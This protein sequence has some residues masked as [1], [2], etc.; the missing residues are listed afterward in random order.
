MV[1]S[2]ER[3]GNIVYLCSPLEEREWVWWAADSC[4]PHHRYSEIFTLTWRSKGQF[5]QLLR[6]ELALIIKSQRSPLRLLVACFLCTTIALTS[7]RKQGMLNP[8]LL[9]I[10]Y[11]LI[12]TTIILFCWLFFLKFLPNCFTKTNYTIYD[13]HVAGGNM[14]LYLMNE[15]WKEIYQNSK[16]G[17]SRLVRSLVTFTC[18]GVHVYLHFPLVFRWRY[19]CYFV[20]RKDRYYKIKDDNY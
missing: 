3:L 17:D 20:T 10:S 7:S 6:Q 14:Y 19:V 1:S 15:D 11:S 9:F 8:N 18:F 4:L 12:I 2:Q 16:W 13:L 5:H